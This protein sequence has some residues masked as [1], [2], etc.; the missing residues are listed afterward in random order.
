MEKRAFFVQNK[1]LFHPNTK[2]RIKIVI[3]QK[4]VAKAMRETMK[5]LTC[6]P[7]SADSCSVMQHGK[8]KQSCWMSMA[9]SVETE[10][11]SDS[12]SCSLEFNGKK[13]PGFDMT[14]KTIDE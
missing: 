3:T 4:K 1:R 8:Q 12:S 2:T 10:E 13:G 9:E 5:M 7:R 6:L 14:Q 11:T